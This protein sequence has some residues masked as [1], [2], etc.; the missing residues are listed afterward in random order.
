MIEA[1]VYALRE[2]PLI[3]DWREVVAA[4]Y[5]AMEYQ[6]LGMHGQRVT[7]LHIAEISYTSERNGR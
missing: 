2:Y 7:S 5:L 4:V 3:P 6:R 1:G